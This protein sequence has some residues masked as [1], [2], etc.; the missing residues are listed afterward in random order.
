LPFAAGASSKVAT[1]PRSLSGSLLD[2]TAPKRELLATLM[3]LK[4]LDEKPAE[5]AAL[6]EL[7]LKHFPS[8]PE[9]LQ[10]QAAGY[11]QL[12]A[13]DWGWRSYRNCANGTD[14]LL[15]QWAIVGCPCRATLQSLQG[16]RK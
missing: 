5:A 15:T 11:A 3:K 7:G 14:R 1:V 16:E 9:F 13:A 10:G 8:Q 2:R 6:S 4:L 12:A